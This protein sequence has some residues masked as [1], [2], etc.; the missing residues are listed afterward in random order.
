MRRTV[1]YA[2]LIAV[3]GLRIG[4]ILYN[5]KFSIRWI[6][7]L[8]PD[9]VHILDRVSSTLRERDTLMVDIGFDWHMLIE[10]RLTGFRAKEIQTKKHDDISSVGH[11][12]KCFLDDRESKVEWGIRYHHIVRGFDRV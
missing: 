5:I 4:C 1:K 12:V 2:M 10:E 9:A 3:A 8:L 7:S 11:S 6:V